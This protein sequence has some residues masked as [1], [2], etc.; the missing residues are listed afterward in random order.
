MARKPPSKAAKALKRAT[1]R[2]LGWL[3]VAALGLLRRVDRK[4]MA[5]VLGPLMRRVGPWFPEHRVGRDNLTAAFPHKAPEEIE[6]ILGGVWDNLGRIAAEFAHI[7]RMTIYNP[8]LAQQPAELDA[9]YDQMTYERFRELREGGR[10]SLVFSA[11]LAN[12]E[13][14]ACAPRMFG[15]PTSILYRRPN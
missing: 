2:I 3:T 7:D 11:H 5:N 12:W 6:R 4:R 14:P 8:E 10:P 15:M 13:L 9:V 1:N